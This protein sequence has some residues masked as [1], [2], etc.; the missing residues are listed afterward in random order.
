MLRN[1][2]MGETGSKFKPRSV[3]VSVL[4]PIDEEETPEEEKKETP[5]DEDYEKKETTSDEDDE[6]PK[7]SL[8]SFFGR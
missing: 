2:I 6:G 3:S 8:R 7:K 5:S 4:K 1:F